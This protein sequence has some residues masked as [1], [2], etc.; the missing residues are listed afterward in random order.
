MCQS[1]RSLRFPLLRKEKKETV[2]PVG[3]KIIFCPSTSPQ[4]WSGKG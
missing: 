2:C 3:K 1:A 4:R